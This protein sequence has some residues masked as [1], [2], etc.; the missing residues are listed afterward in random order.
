M[1]L[2]SFIEAS[3]RSE[4]LLLQSSCQFAGE[5]GEWEYIVNTAVAAI[6][7]EPQLRTVSPSPKVPKPSRSHSL[8]PPRLLVL[9]VPLVCLVAV[10]LGCLR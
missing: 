2:W 5:V 9:L 8:K 1:V 6:E 7:K 4:P 10:L 3:T